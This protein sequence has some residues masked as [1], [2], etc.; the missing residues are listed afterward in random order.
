[1]QAPSAGRSMSVPLSLLVAILLSVPLHA[2]PIP[3]RHPQGSTHGFLVVKTI[4]GTLIATGD[5]TQV[6]HGDRVSSRV[7]FHF[8]DGSLDDDI[9][10]FSQRR[11][12]RLISDHHIQRGLSF[13][14]PSD[15]FIDATTGQITSRTKNGKVT[16]EHLDLPPDVS[17]GLPPN[18]LLNILSSTPETKLSFVA[19]T[20]KPRLIRVSIKPAG[21]V[22]FSVAGTSRKAVDYVLHVELGGVTGVIAPIIGKQPADYHIWILEGSA[23]AFIREEGQFYEGGPIWCIEQTSPT[24]PADRSGSK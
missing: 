12:F 14:E 7:T 20:A 13:P 2:E 1:M 6:I 11:V 4:E 3:V 19:P 22:P 10:V 15:I 21:K 9:T 5:A 23:P 8:R 16:Q 17:N 18:L 24:F